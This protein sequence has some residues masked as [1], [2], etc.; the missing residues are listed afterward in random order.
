MMTIERSLMRIVL[1]AAVWTYA[2]PGASF[3]V[4]ASGG[5]VFPTDLHA[6]RV[7]TLAGGL[8]NPWGLTFLPDGR[9]LVTERPGRLRLVDQAGKVGDP[10]EGVPAVFARGQG[11]LL[12]VALDPRFEKNRFVYLSYAEPGREGAGTA[13]GRG[14]LAEDRIEEFTVIFRQVPKTGT[15]VHFGSR[16][17]F[18][19]DGK[20]FITLGERGERERAQDFSVH[21]GQVIRIGPDGTVPD[22]NPF[23]GLEGYRPETWSH[24]HR[25]PQ[26]AALHPATG[27]L[28]TVEHGAR[29]GDEIN[30]PMRGKNY[31]WPVISYGRHYSGMKI[32]EGTR[33]E[34]MEQPVYYWDPSIAPSGMVF[35]TSDRFPAWRGNLL[36]GA[37]RG[38]M[39][40]RLE[41]DGEKVVGE[42]R[43]LQKLGER[44]RDVRQGP[45]GLIY[46]LTDSPKGRILRLEPVK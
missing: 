27:R 31:G 46:L 44:I 22:D 3:A 25:N 26:G 28:W 38:Q 29:G 11:G 5:D 39:L 21:R 32:G 37:L 40:V 19:R 17:V 45:D 42:E 4:A 33:K 10:L 23:V 43:M 12:D 7:V 14:R 35:V 15:G 18:S 6:V 1:L 16:L 41:L 2:L 36:V 34:G 8:A 9:M 13:V 24:G 30:V 20:L